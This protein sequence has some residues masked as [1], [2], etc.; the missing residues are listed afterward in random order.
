MAIDEI[1]DEETLG[2]AEMHSRT[3]G[4]SDY[5]AMDEMDG[6]HHARKIIRHLRWNKLGPGPTEPDDAPAVRPGRVDGLRFRRR[7][8]PVRDQ[9]SL[10]S[11]ARRKPHRGVQAALRRKARVWLGLHPRLPGGCARQQ[12]H[13][14]LRGSQEGR[15]VHPA[16]QPHEH[17][18]VVRPQ[19]HRFHGGLQGRAGRHHPQRCQDDQRRVEQHRAPLQSDG[20]RQLRSRQLRH[21]RQE[22]QPQVHLQLA[23]PSHRCDGAQTTRRR[24]GDRGQKRSRRARVSR[25]TKNSWQLKPQGWKR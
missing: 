5:L 8:N 17:A 20:R 24:D 1:V 6:L 11:I 23:Q 19:H 15:T 10:C 16:V 21:G 13:L 3:S 25:W 22:L 18:V 2:G 4:L 7:S 14:V 9:G 12:R